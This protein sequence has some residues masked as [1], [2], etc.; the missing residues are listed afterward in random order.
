MSPNSYR[1]LEVQFKDFNVTYSE[2]RIIRCLLKGYSNAVIAAHLG[3]KLGTIKV[4]LTTIYRKTGVK[5]R[6]EFIS[7]FNHGT[8]FT[9]GQIRAA[10]VEIGLLSTQ[11]EKLL[12]ALK[13]LS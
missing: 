9:L 12:N 8:S 10:A 7:K 11:I 13:S 1:D 4:S 6:S 3:L 5:S 2:L